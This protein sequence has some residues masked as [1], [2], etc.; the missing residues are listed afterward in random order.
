MEG[1]ARSTATYSRSTRRARWTFSWLSPSPVASRSSLRV[2]RLP[3]VA[4][5]STMEDEQIAG[6]RR[7]LVGGGVEHVAAELFGQGHVGVGG[8]D[9]GDRLAFDCDLF[10]ARWCWWARVTARMRPRYLALSRRLRVERSENPRRGGVRVHH[11]HR[12]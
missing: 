10:A 6:G 7:Q 5:K 9:V 3:W 12:S 8:L 11:G 4:V 2:K 1:P